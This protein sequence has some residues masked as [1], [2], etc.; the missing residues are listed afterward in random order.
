MQIYEVNYIKI[1]VFNLRVILQKNI[2]LKQRSY[3]CVYNK[4]KILVVLSK[5][6]YFIYI[7][8]VKFI[9][10]KMSV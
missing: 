7:F 2:I 1:F 8:F 10:D 4:T 9:T 5:K 6:L 3:N